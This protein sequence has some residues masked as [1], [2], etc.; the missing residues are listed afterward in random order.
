MIHPAFAQRTASLGMPTEL[1]VSNYGMLSHYDLLAQQ[2]PYGMTDL[3]SKKDSIVEYQLARMIFQARMR[4]QAGISN[5][6]MKQA[7]QLHPD[8]IVQRGAYPPRN[9]MPRAHPQ[10]GLELFRTSASIVPDDNSEP[11]RG[12][13]VVG[14]ASET[15]S[16]GS[17]FQCS[18]TSHQEVYIDTIRDTDV[19]CGRGGRSNH[20][21][22][23]KRYRHVISEMKHTYKG[24]ATKSNKTDLSRTIVDHVCKYGGRFVK[25]EETTG[26]YYI[27]TRGEAR[28]K[29]SQALRESKELKWTK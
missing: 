22:G 29:T 27:L 1:P 28:K 20:H 10:Q 14:D 23:N 9:T 19:L 24:T 6:G 2:Q 8:P 18:K 17:S 5:L 11:S 21:P 12:R 3:R 13:Q 25:K 26:R 7:T 16:L 15:S 4:A